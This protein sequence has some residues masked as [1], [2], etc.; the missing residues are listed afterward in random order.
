MRRKF[1]DKF[2]AKV[3]LEALQNGTRISEVASKYKVH[4]NQVTEWKKELVGKAVQVFEKKD[5]KAE[6]EW[7]KREE[8]LL[9]II[10]IRDVELEFQKKSLKKLGLL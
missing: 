6:K 3:A 4:P 8:E 1:D 5:N 2:K 7:E 10:G 9:K